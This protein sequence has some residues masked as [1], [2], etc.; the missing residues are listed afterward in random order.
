MNIETRSDI[1]GFAPSDSRWTA[2]DL[3]TYDGPGSHTGSGAT[4]AEAIADLFAKFEVNHG[5]EERP[6]WS[7]IQRS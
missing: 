5:Q 6:D 4:Q 7:Q 2:I 3:D 1:T